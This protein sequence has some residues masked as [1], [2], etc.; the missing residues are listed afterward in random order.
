MTTA[1]HFAR[2]CLGGVMQCCI[3]YNMKLLI[4]QVKR[5]RP[6]NEFAHCAIVLTQG[7]LT[8]IPSSYPG[9]WSNLQTRFLIWSHCTINFTLVKD[10]NILHKFLTTF[11]YNALVKYFSLNINILDWMQIY[12]VD[13]KYIFEIIKY[14]SLHTKYF[15]IEHKI[16]FLKYRIFFVKCKHFIDYK[17]IFSNVKHFSLKTNIISLNTKLQ[18]CYK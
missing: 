13:Y 12:L 17:Y 18:F 7:Y 3:P 5:H 1:R 4:S 14:F 15:F 11:E 16:Y 8:Q 10:K 6:R 2:I 9:Y